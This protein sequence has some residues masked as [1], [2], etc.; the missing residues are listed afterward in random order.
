MN[1]NLLGISK[2]SSDNEESKILHTDNFWKT[3]NS[4]YKDSWNFDKKMSL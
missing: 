4:P 2:Y 1:D 3:H